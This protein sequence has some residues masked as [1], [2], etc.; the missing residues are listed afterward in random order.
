MPHDCAQRTAHVSGA[1]TGASTMAVTM[2]G[3]DGPRRT[4][5][6]K[7]EST[8]RHKCGLVQ[9]LCAPR[10]EVR[11]NWTRE[12]REAVFGRAAVLRTP[13][14]SLSPLPRI[15]AQRLVSLPVA[16]WP[17]G[18]GFGT[19]LNGFIIGHH[20]HS[21]RIH[22]VSTPRCSRTPAWTPDCRESVRCAGAVYYKLMTPTT[23]RGIW[24]LR[25]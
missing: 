2:D 19:E 13:R 4:G 12:S 21:A 25:S 11:R 16:G 22:R 10:H 14:N 8:E 24:D 9:A 3:T 23:R 1:H 17:P 15:V 20:R 6:C 18:A 7:Q 5:D